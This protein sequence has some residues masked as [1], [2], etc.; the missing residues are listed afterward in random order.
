MKKWR[1]KIDT[2]WGKK[3][4]VVGNRC[5]HD[6]IGSCMPINPAEFPDLFEQVEEKTD[7]DLFA[8][9]VS[10]GYDDGAKRTAK[11]ISHALLSQN[12]INP[13]FLKSLRKKEGE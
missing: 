8:E 12:A 5:W 9:W 10:C 4:D 13:E 3:G 6:S 2:P 11:N 1:C 7:E